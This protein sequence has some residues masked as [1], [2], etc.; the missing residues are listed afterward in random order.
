MMSSPPPLRYDLH[1]R[2]L[3]QGH[4]DRKLCGLAAHPSRPQEF[5]TV[6]DDK[7]VRVWDAEKKSLV[8][9]AVLDTM[10]RC[11]HYSPDG[12]MI[13]AFVEADGCFSVSTSVAPA[14]R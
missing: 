9:M 14:A 12:S 4:Y 7:T 8:K 13:A 11:C 1:D 3:V 6:G 5:A 2:P 10:A